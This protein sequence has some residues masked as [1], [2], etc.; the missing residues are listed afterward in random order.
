MGLALSVEEGIGHATS[1]ENGVGFFEQVVDDADLVGDFGTADDGDEGFV[2]RGESLAHIGEL[3]FHEQTG[4]GLRDEVGDAFG[5]GMSSMGAAE[6]VVDVD[7]AEAGE[8][9]C[10][11]G[12]VGLFLG[13]EAEVLEEESLAGF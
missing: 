7:V 11:V 1:D 10:E 4:S 8:L 13:M 2:G 6:G 3:F 5:G 9:P 12:V